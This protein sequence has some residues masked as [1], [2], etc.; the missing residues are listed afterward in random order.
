M[1]NLVIISVRFLVVRW[2][3]NYLCAVLNCS[4][5]LSFVHRL[6]DS[7]GNVLWLVLG[8][9]FLSNLSLGNVL[10]LDLG[11]V[12]VLSFVLSLVLRL[13]F[14]LGNVLL[15]NFGFGNV[16]SMVLR[17][18]FGFDNS[19][20]LGFVQGFG[21]NFGLVNSLV[22]GNLKKNYKFASNY[23]FIRYYLHYN[24]ISNII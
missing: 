2:L 13:V 6:L 12:G 14:G 11:L 21:H 10:F 17:Y 7:F 15:L 19:F 22:M 20:V 3:F 8:D 9:V 1:K 16:F 5:V 24:M 18:G 23:K 4:L